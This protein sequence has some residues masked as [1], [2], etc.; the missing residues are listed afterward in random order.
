MCSSSDF[1]N[2]E[3]DVCRVFDA[4]VSIVDQ[5]TDFMFIFSF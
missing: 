5:I 4:C 2:F 3:I 1:Y